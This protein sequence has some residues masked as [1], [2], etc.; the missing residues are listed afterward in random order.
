MVGSFLTP[1]LKDIHELKIFDLRE[2]KYDDVEFVQGSMDNPIDVTEALKGV[3]LFI[4]LTMKNPQGG[5]ET[6]QNL[7]DIQNNYDLNTKGLHTFLY[8]AQKEGVMRGIHTST[9][10]VHYR[11]RL[12][13]PS[14]ELVPKDTPSVYGLTK[15]F[16]EEICNYFCRWF[17]MNIIALRITGPRNDQDWKREIKDKKD[18]NP[19]G[20]RLW[21]THEKDL[22]NAYIASLK[23]IQ[24]GNSRFDTVF[25]AGDP[26]N[27]EHNLSKAIHLLKWIPEMNPEDYRWR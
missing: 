20:S 6:T 16:G 8:L 5:S 17:G 25:I 4:N 13:Y 22:A 3:D 24:E 11:K 10:S 14:E 12:H 18:K 1:Y 21:I 23:F 7:E 9:M 27:K 19:D 26:E 15:G 2:P